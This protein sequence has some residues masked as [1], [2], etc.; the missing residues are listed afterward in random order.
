MGQPELKPPPE[1]GPSDKTSSATTPGEAAATGPRV[2]ADPWETGAGHMLMSEELDKPKWTLPPIVPVVIALVAVAIVIAVFVLGTSAP[3]AGGK[4]LGIYAADI[5]GGNRTLVTIQLSVENR[6]KKPLWIQ[7]VR[8]QLNPA[9]QKSG[10]AP[11][12][13]TAASASDLNRYLQAFPDLAS[14][15]ADPLPL[16]QKIEPG[17]SIQG[18]VL[19]AFPVAKEAFDKRQSLKVIVQPFDHAAITLQQ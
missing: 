16:D 5:P 14:H 10:D 12:E 7:G 2:A 19:V 11:L 18:M 13:D 3:K 15:K 8:V 4:I 1:P 17:G 9:D 6:D